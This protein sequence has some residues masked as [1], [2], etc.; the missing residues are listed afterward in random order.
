MVGYFVADT[1]VFVRM[2]H[3]SPTFG[4]GRE[5][6]WDK[7]PGHFRFIILDIPE[8]ICLLQ[9]LILLLLQG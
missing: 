2:I 5:T 9:I 6:V 3:E 4:K 8:F 1:M 7:Q